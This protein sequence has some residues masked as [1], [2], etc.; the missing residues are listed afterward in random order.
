M[1][2]CKDM[3]IYSC[4]RF[5][6]LEPHTSELYFCAKCFP[7]AVS[8]YAAYKFGCPQEKDAIVN[9]R[10]R[11]DIMWYWYPD[12]H[13]LWRTYLWLVDEIHMRNVFQSLLKESID[14]TSHDY[15]TDALVTTKKNLQHTLYEREQYGDNHGWKEI[16]TRRKFFKRKAKNVW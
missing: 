8:V 3:G 4:A 6:D 1:K 2:I 16:Q 14:T 10:G 5:L 15:Y 11:D 12:T 7:L 9:A 13:I